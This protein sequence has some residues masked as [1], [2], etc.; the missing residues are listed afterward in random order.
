MLID[1]LGIMLSDNILSALI[2]ATS[3]SS[4]HITPAYY[5][6]TIGFGKKSMSGKEAY[7]HSGYQ[8]TGER[9]SLF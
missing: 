1:N 9:S 6:L 3:F 7:P 4:A 5:A 8:E 2:F